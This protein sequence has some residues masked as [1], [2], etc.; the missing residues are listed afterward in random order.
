MQRFHLIDLFLGDV[1]VQHPEVQHD[2]AARIFLRKARDVPAV[3]SNG[4]GGT[5]T[6]RRQPCHR[7]AEAVTDHAGFIYFLRPQN[8]S[9]ASMSFTASSGL[10]WRAS[11]MPFCRSSPT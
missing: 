9:A 10:I 2:R 7:S 3:I 11:A 4:R 1:L 8:S 6:R 5:E